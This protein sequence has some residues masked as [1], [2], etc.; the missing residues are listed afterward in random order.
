M[1]ILRQNRTIKSHALTEYISVMPHSLTKNL[2]VRPAHLS[3]AL[4]KLSAFLLV[5][6]IVL[7]TSCRSSF[8]I[9]E[10]NGSISEQSLAVLTTTAETTTEAPTVTAQS[11]AADPYKTA[12]TYCIDTDSFSQQ[13]NI[14]KRIYPASMTKFLTAYTALKYVKPEVKFTVG[15]E[16]D[17]VQP[18]SSLCL[19]QKGNILTLYDLLTGLLLMSGND[20]A[21]TVA[22][23]TAR[24]LRPNDSLTDE[25]AVAYFCELM[26]QTA[27]EIGMTDSHFETPDGW[28]N[29]KQYTTTN[30]LLTL[31]KCAIKNQSIKKIISI[32][33]TSVT[34]AA[35]GSVTWKNH[36]KLIDP[37]SEYY[38]E[39]FI[40]GK[41]GT[42]DIAG[43][44]LISLFQKNSK[45]YVIIVTGCES[46]EARCAATLDL[47]NRIK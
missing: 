28:D 45:T 5:A 4:K 16:L 7:L 20:A 40:G 47:Y 17:M 6:A 10:A 39:D 14:D 13:K 19:I 32:K 35:G 31:T 11:S 25:Q 36:I 29:D 2:T 23:G 18:E 41:T 27:A 21:Y 8:K 15:S 3:I 12:L 33:E 26:N 30:D 22:V 42:T 43:Y 1:R 38:C 34:F 9:V 44:C 46:D 37:E 24:Q